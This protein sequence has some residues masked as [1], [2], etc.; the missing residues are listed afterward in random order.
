LAAQCL[1]DVEAV[2]VEVAG[3]PDGGGRLIEL[4]VL[5]DVKGGLATRFPS[6]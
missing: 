6:C 2:E 3:V 5:S 1:R 4:Q